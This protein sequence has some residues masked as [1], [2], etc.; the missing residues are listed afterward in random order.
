[1][2][3]VE[4][5]FGHLMVVLDTGED[6]GGRV[7]ESKGEVGLPACS[8]VKLVDEDGSRGGKTIL[9]EGTPLLRFL[10]VDESEGFDLSERE[11]SFEM[12][13]RGLLLKSRR[14]EGGRKGRGGE[15]M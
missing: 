13:V 9:G 3:D 14:G 6:D 10:V 11:V 5:D 12:R 2:L 15:W 7:E 8:K 4:D 1:M